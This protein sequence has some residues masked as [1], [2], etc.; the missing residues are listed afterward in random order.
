M[1]ADDLC[2]AVFKSLD[3]VKKC[4]VTGEL[5]SGKKVLQPVR[6]FASET[7]RAYGHMSRT[8][9]GEQLANAIVSKEQLLYIRRQ[10]FELSMP[11]ESRWRHDWMLCARTRTCF[12]K[13]TYL[14]LH[15]CSNLVGGFASCPCPRST[16]SSSSQTPKCPRMISSMMTTMWS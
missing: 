11:C 8:Y 13:R 1:A 14:I 4:T 9:A 6:F 16:A 3:E 7:G 5:V 2:P 10:H 15:V 12:V